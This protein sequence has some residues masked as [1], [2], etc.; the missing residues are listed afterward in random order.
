[1]R[2]RRMPQGP[3]RQGRLDPD[4]SPQRQPDRRPRRNSDSSV[5]DT[6]KNMTEEERKQREMRRRERERERER[7]HREQSKRVNRKIDIIDQ[8]DATGIYGSGSMFPNPPYEIKS[9]N[10]GSS[11]SPRRALRCP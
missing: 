1:M 7:R 4:R 2:A 5:M 8:L 3:E 6:D 9:P 10:M 11:F